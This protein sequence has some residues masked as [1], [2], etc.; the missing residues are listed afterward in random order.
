MK[1]GTTTLIIFLTLLA[2]VIGGVR[3][4][5]IPTYYP[6]LLKIEIAQ[7]NDPLNQV[8]VSPCLLYTSPSPRD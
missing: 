6:Q 1:S 2:I 5:L 8:Q 4:Y 3:Y 7:E